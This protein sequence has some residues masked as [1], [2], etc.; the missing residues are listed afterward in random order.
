VAVQSYKI[1]VVDDFERFR[2]FVTSTLREKRGF[3]LTEAS[4][5]LIA[6]QQV[7]ELQPD[8]ILL[9]IGLPSLNGLEV[10]KRIRTLNPSRAILFVSQET[11]ASIVQEA[12]DLGAMGFIRKSSARSDLL[13]AKPC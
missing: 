2:E 9:D 4:D 12:L 8:L 10:A 3:Q 5:G 13:P 11:S 1:L 7:E 6:V